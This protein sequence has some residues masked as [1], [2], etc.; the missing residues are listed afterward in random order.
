VSVFFYLQRSDAPTCSWVATWLFVAKV[1]WRSPCPATT[2]PPPSDIT[3]SART[4][5]GLATSP[6]VQIHTTP[7]KKVQYWNGEAVEK[8]LSVSSSFLS[9][10][11]LVSPVDRFSNYS[12]MK[13][14]PL[15]PSLCWNL[16]TKCGK[17]FVNEEAPVSS[18]NQ[19]FWDN[20]CRSLP[21]RYGRRR[22]TIK[23]K[24]NN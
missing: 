12:Y 13:I 3:S 15:L 22:L 24:W 19:S 5:S 4:V 6:C 14:Y 23:C 21:V 18:F 2:R 11:L 9:F 20:I 1:I 16:A 8:C 17:E 7:T 10:S